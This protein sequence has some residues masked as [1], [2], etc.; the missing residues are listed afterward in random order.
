MI[1]SLRA[2]APWMDVATDILERVA[3]RPL[4]LV[5][6]TGTGKSHYASLMAETAS[7]SLV[8]PPVGGDGDNR[9]LAGT[10]RGYTGAQPALPIVA[11][12]QH[13][14]AN[15]LIELEE[16][17]KVSSDRRHGNPHD[18]LLG[19]LELSTARCW[20]DRCV[21]DGV[22][23][24]PSRSVGAHC[25][26]A[27]RPQS[28]LSRFDVVTIGPPISR[29]SERPSMADAKRDAEG[30]GGWRTTICDWT[31]SRSRWSST[32]IACL[33]PS[34]RCNAS[35][36]SPSAIAFDACVA[37]FNRSSLRASALRP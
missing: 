35:S 26:Y 31:R 12:A 14:S 2:V 9:S 21:S 13:R 30:P 4:L 1:A 22:C 33:V 29:A 37:T 19:M 34:E 18:T 24:P 23:R 8:L 7:L 25:E 28:L 36:T 15:P 32:H 5:G 17:E 6:P 11:M 3:F 20:Y 16:F 10:A 27:D